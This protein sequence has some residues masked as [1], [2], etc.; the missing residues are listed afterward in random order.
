LH[1]S[2]R[3]FW[4]GRFPRNGP[5]PTRNFWTSNCDD[6]ILREATAL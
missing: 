4:Q 5:T 1:V 2:F 3:H 6:L